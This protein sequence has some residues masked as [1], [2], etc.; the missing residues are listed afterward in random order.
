MGS[1]SLILFGLRP[2][3][4]DYDITIIYDT[5]NI[6]LQKLEIYSEGFAANVAVMQNLFC[7]YHS[8]TYKD[9]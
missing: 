8:R 4:L 5:E 1:G 2:R 6:R 3:N 7:T 9:S